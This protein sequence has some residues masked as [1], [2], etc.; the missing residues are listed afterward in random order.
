MSRYFV[1]NVQP[2]RACE[3]ESPFQGVRFP[4]ANEMPMNSFQTVAA[5]RTPL[6]LAVLLATAQIA[7]VALAAEPNFPITAGQRSTA[8]QVAQAGVPLSDLSPDAPDRYTVKRGDTLWDISSLYLRQPWRWP[9]LWG[10]NLQQIRNP[11]LIFPGQVLVLTRIGDRA[12][13]GFE[14]PG[15]GDMPTVKLSPRIRAE[16]LA[17]SAI[18]PIPLNV[19][20]PFLTDSLVVDEATHS[21][22][23]RIVAAPENRVLLSRGDRAYARG[24]YGNAATQ[25]GTALTL[26]PGQAR[27]HRI[28]RNAVPLK[29]P[30][31]GEILGYEAQFIGK[32]NLVRAEAVQTVDKPNEPGAVSIEPATIDI[33]LSKEEIRIGDRLLPEPDREV[34]TYIPQAPAGPQAGAIVKAFGNAVQYAGQNQVVVINRGTQAGLRRGDV[35]AILKDANQVTDRTD[36]AKTTL[37]L[38]GERNGLMMVFRTFDRVSYALVLQITDG[39][40]VGDRFV[41]P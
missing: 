37:Q 32:S 10:M 38:P 18:G 8:Q 25:D 23:P 9:E 6:T 2:G 17:D 22:A 31:T 26:A 14:V 30:V 28:Y 5:L 24:Q 15:Q 21:R 16:S 3:H 33:T 34:P 7:P 19:I 41:N 1:E 27:T 13:L 39:V 40:K 36:P 29:D 20:E 35:L 4:D 11:H 12:V